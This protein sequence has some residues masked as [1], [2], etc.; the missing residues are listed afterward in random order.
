[1]DRVNKVMDWGLTLEV[2]KNFRKHITNICKAVT[3]TL[4]F[5]VRTSAEFNDTRI[6]MM[7]YNAYVRSKLE[8]GAVT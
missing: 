2:E 5:I 8:F 4:W 6:A 3:K 7:L 1:M